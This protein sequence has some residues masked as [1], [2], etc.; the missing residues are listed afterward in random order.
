MEYN[1]LSKKANNIINKFFN[2]KEIIS[3]KKQGNMMVLINMVLNQ[4]YGH[5]ILL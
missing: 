1:K 3:K 2:E 5:Y 4:T